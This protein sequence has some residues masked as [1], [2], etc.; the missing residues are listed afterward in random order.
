MPLCRWWAWSTITWWS[1]SRTRSWR[2]AFLMKGDKQ[3]AQPCRFSFLPLTTPWVP[4][5]SRFA[6]KSE[7]PNHLPHYT[8]FPYGYGPASTDTQVSG[9]DFSVLPDATEGSKGCEVMPKDA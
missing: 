2:T 8:R 3:M 6:R 9:H 4:S 7:L 1:A 5:Y